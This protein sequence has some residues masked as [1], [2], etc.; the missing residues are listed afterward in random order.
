MF[1]VQTHRPEWQTQPKGVLTA[2]NGQA[3]AWPGHNAPARGLPQCATHRAAVV[4]GVTQSA[5][6]ALLLAFLLPSCVAATPP[7]APSSAAA[8]AH[9]LERTDPPGALRHAD[10][11]AAEAGRSGD[12]QALAIAHLHRSHALRL[13]GRH[14]EAT[15]AGQDARRLAMAA[16]DERT[17]ASALANLAVLYETGGLDTEALPL[18]RRAMQMFER[19][20]RRDALASTLLNLGNLFE[21][22]DELAEAMAA[23]R[24]ALDIKREIGA[25]GVG[26]A[27]G[28]MA[29]VASR[30]GNHEDALQLLTEAV[31]AH[32][33]EGDTLGT[34]VALRNQADVLGAL[35]RFDEATAALDRADRLAGAAG[36]VLGLSAVAEGRAQLLQRRAAAGAGEGRLLEAAL[37]ANARAL[38]LAADAEPSRRARLLRQRADL[39]EATGDSA[40]ALAALRESEDL[41]AD[42]RQLA[43]DRRYAVLSAYFDSARQNS[44]IEALEEGAAADAQRLE[45]QDSLRNALAAGGVL[46]AALAGWLLGL[47]RRRQRAAR[48]LAAHNRS[49]AVALAAAERERLHAEEAERI[50]R[51]MLRIAAEE[52]R[53]PLTSA[54]GSAERL[55]TLVADQPTLRRDAAGVADTLQQLVHVVGELVESA[56]LERSDVRLACE[57]V[58]LAHLLR[59]VCAHWALRAS[60][61]RQELTCNAPPRLMLTGDRARLREALEHLV[62]NALRSTPAGK[63]IDTTLAIEGAVAAVR[64]RDQ[65]PGL[66]EQDRTRLFDKLQ[67]GARRPG[68]GGSAGLGLWLV[69]RI[70][71][72]HGGG[73]EAV[74]SPYGDGCEFVLRLPL[75]PCPAP[76]P[77]PAPVRL[78]GAATTGAT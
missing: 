10:A 22:R 33:R 20:G 4:M 24:R 18:H 25:P 14:G 63:R 73:I 38:D 3:S 43:S 69:R 39:A 44:R 57:D 13:L 36:H 2:T 78:P 59:G 34:A 21:A 27:L 41:F 11:A 30:R 65:G 8:Q 40:T 55:L 15:V 56:E 46:L 67:R 54:L 77:D 7:P 29:L 9:R 35:A 71:E 75:A 61:R 5:R 16:K 60:E 6:G 26:A 48:E 74:P 62:S 76:A 47:V 1:G 42:E 12:R 51:E 45:R 19:Q 64:V 32:D 66:R 50:N 52:L 70:A 37:A 28:N 53:V 68:N 72:L 49:L 17:E 31:A 23:Y 58:D